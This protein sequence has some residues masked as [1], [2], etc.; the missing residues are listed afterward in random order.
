MIRVL[1]DEIANRIAAGEVIERPASVVKELVE[2]ALDAGARRIRVEIAE[3]GRKRIAVT[4]DGGG[5]DASDLGR[6]LLPHATSKIG[7]VEDLHKIGTFGFRGEALASIASV[8]RTVI[9]TRTPGSPLGSRVVSDGGATAAVEPAGA[10][11]GTTVEVHNLFFN[12]PARRNFLKQDR[13]ELA[14]IVEVLTRLALPD[15]DWTLELVSD[16]KRVL[17][18]EA[19]G[20]DAHRLADLFGTALAERLVPVSGSRGTSRLRGF[21]GP[22]DLVRPSARFQQVLV[23]GRPIKDR[24]LSYAIAEAY[25]GLIMPRDYPVAFL[26]LSVDP[27]MVDVNVHPAKTE[28]RFRDPDALFGLI[29]RSIREK[30]G[31]GAL[32]D[33]AAAGAGAA[34]SPAPAAAPGPAAW[35]DFV[36]EPAPRPWEPRELA[37]DAPELAG[38][39]GGQP[40]ALPAA[41]FLQAH[42]SYVVAE[43]PE[44]I[45]VFDQHALHERKLFDE[46]MARLAASD[47][48]DQLLL[49]PYVGDVE[50]AD[51]ELL[52]SHAAALARLGLRVEDFGAR[53]VVLRSLPMPLANASAERVFHGVV[54]TLREAGRASARDVVQ[55]VIA[56][57]ACKAAVKFGDGLPDAEVRALLAYEQAHPEAR[58]CPHGRNTSLL[59]SL[60]ELETRFQRKK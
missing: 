38:P 51:K 9:T 29:L 28:V 31:G 54:E 35:A 2:N 8:S 59:L 16:G 1:P 46:L 18:A 3:G 20:G 47:G 56:H 43:T 55:D 41:R 37:F 42:R 27:A 12:V 6:C 26:Y 4:D 19:G 15:P 7:A 40:T 30:I 32:A 52:L 50:P 13:F 21:V 25:R 57:V 36:R 14:Q 17:V 39:R 44:G 33:A 60:R 24:R 11:F 45:R 53:S 23:N 34:A 22:V 58:N 49:V 10:P 5:M 48:E